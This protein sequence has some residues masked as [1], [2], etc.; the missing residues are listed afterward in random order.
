MKPQIG[1]LALLLAWA[2]CT[3]QPV[4]PPVA[5][6]SS[7]EFWGE[8]L[9]PEMIEDPNETATADVFSPKAKNTIP[10]AV[11]PPAEQVLPELTHSPA[12]AVSNNA[13]AVSAENEAQSNTGRDVGHN[14]DGQFEKLILAFAG[15]PVA[16]VEPDDAQRPVENSAVRKDTAAIIVGPPLPACPSGTHDGQAFT[17]E[18]VP[19][20]L[21]QIGLIDVA[22]RPAEK[23]LLAGLRAYDDAQFTKAEKNLR[24]ALKLGLVSPRDRSAAHKHLAFIYCTSRRINLCK[25]A[26]RE[27]RAADPAFV[28]RRSESG[29]PVWGPVYKRVLP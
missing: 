1:L 7:A 9:F 17:T 24:S 14:A 16:K 21:A 23:A 18:C 26:F 19:V 3:S 15:Q 20:P 29:H 28:L 2:G 8:P 4:A 22:A 27:A 12:E 6:A 25:T 5:M 13:P 11:E 10:E